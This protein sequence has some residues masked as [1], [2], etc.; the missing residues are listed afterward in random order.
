MKITKAKLKQIIK[1]ELGKVL[2]EGMVASIEKTDVSGAEKLMDPMH[3]AHSYTAPS[4]QP[5][6][7]DD[8]TFIV[9]LTDGTKIT[10]SMDASGSISLFDT[11]DREIDNEALEQEILN[12]I[13]GK[14]L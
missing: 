3:R 2:N 10:A 8:E 5:F 6:V 11:D 7:S 14:K 13:K 4:L 9:T 1:E 12:T